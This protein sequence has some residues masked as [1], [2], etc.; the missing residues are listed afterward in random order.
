MTHG[1]SFLPQVDTILVLKD[2]KQS[3]VG[4]FQQLLDRKGAFADFLKTYFL[5]ENENLTE[6]GKHG[7]SR[8]MPH[9]ESD[10]TVILSFVMKVIAQ[11]GSL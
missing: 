1:V 5:E 8:G 10:L 3:E 6:E 9:Y 11:L 7:L 4:S 2:G